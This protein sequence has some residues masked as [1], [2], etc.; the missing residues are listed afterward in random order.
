[1]CIF[2]SI[3]R[4][5]RFGSFNV[6]QSPGTGFMQSTKLQEII[7]KTVKEMQDEEEHCARVLS[8]ISARRLRIFQL[9]V[10]DMIRVPRSFMIG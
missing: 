8:E 10:L 7:R 4:W 5:R 9:S 6:F 3:L 2:F 1:M